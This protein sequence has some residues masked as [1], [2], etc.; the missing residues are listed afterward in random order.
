MLKNVL[1]KLQI[2]DAF[3]IGE[4]RNS[5]YLALHVLLLTAVL[6]D[7]LG[8]CSANKSTVRMKECYV[9]LMQESLLHI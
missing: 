2:A 7:I 1:G 3:H 5:L 8:L 9:G 4:A 6:L